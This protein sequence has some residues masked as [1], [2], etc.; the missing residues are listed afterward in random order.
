MY[1]PE[2][3]TALKDALRS[4]YWYK[5]DLRLFLSAV[6]LPTGLVARQG[7]HDPQ[8][9]KVR[10]VG[11]VLDELVA[12]G[13]EGLG[14]MRRLIKAVLEIPNFNHLRDLDDGA[15]KV[16]GARR[17]VETLRELVSRHDESF[18]K[19]VTERGN[20]GNKIMEAVK[21]RNDDLERLTRRFNELVGTTDPQARGFLFESFL[22]DMFAAYD[23]NPRGSFKITGEQIDGAFEFEGTQFLVEA[24]WEKKRQSAPSLDSFSKKV[25]RK[26]ENTLGLFIALEGYTEED[27]AAF[28][29]GRPAVILMDG[30][31]LALVLQG[32]ID[33]R[34]LLKQKIRHASQTGNPYLRARDV[35]K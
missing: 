21:R 2:V 28:R 6:E 10:I 20:V 1:P 5:D 23:L 33:F 25:E 17:N 12:S 29:G 4:I 15:A 22:H 34:E 18:S 11:K 30:E 8:E 35:N 16:Q 7:W 14:P 24:R 9:Y 32:L 26:L 31:D 13:E 3:I 19:S 27:L